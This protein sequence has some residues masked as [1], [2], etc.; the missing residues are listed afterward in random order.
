M[1]RNEIKETNPFW[2]MTPEGML[3]LHMSLNVYNMNYS[4]KSV[5]IYGNN[6]QTFTSIKKNDQVII[7]LG[8]QETCMQYF[9]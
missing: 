1:K 9:G 4:Y 6:L 7:S 2:G 3:Q 5:W 8:I